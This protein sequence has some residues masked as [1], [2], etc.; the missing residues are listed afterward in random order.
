MP[1]LR[2]PTNPF[3]VLLVLAGL[4]FCLTACA[5]GMMAFRADRRGRSSEALQAPS[6]LV[7]LL[8]R[9]GEIIMASELVILGV[10]TLGAMATDGWRARHAAPPAE[11]QA[12]QL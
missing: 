11:S 12:K 10:A 3:Y 7:D 4:A 9:Q 8:D 2:E 1:K 6:S 5:Y